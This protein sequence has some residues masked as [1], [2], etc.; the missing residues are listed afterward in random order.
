[1]K[2]T[3]L[4]GT[5]KGP[6]L[7]GFDTFTSE[8]VLILS[9]LYFAPIPQAAATLPAEAFLHSE[10]PAQF[11]QLVQ[12]SCDEIEQLEAAVGP[13]P[14][15]GRLCQAKLTVEQRMRAQLLPRG[16]AIQ[17]GGRFQPSW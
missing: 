17:D 5:Q 6:V 8:R 4:V 3:N 15:V 1:M 7:S 11:P 16:G 9:F 13:G 10:Y 14:L 12:L 2:I